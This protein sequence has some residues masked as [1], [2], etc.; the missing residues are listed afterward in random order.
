MKFEETVAGIGTLTDVRRIAGAH[1]VDHNQLSEAELRDAVVKVKPQYS[2]EETVRSAFDEALYGNPDKDCRV[3]SRLLLVD[4]LLEQYDFVLSEGE[5]EERLIA[6][7]QA[8]VDRSNEVDISDLACGKRNGSRYQDIELYAF[9]LETAWSH[10][11]SVSP[12]EA[13]LLRRLRER[14][15]INEW[16]HRT[17]EAKLS[18]YPKPGNELHTR[19]E[20]SKTRRYLQGLGLL[21]TVRD[22]NSTD[23][24]VIPQELAQLMREIVGKDMRTDCYRIMLGSKP[25]RSKNHLQ[26]ILTQ[27]CV[28]YSRYDNLDTLAE[29]VV[30]NVP[31]LQA[32]ACTSPRY[33]LSSDELAAWCRELDIS[34][35]GS[36]EERVHRVVAHFDALRPQVQAEADERAGWYDFYTELAWRD[37]ATLRAQHVIDKD[38]EIEAKFEGATRYL[39]SELLNHSPL[40]QSGS[41]HPDGLVSLGAR[42]LMWDNKSKETPVSL[43]DH[44][45]QFHDYIE[46]TDKHVPVF[47]VIG[48]DFTEDSEAEAIRYHAK[49]FERNILLIT[50]DE[51]KTLAEEW[52]SP[53]NRNREE[54]FPLGYLA[55]T[56]RF[57]RKSIGKL[58]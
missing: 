12:D 36:V 44:I 37:R 11:D 47:L 5:T 19:A 24:D 28:E 41:N 23:Y 20:T 16:D 14:L 48:P 42:Y 55:T 1:V 8:I 34:P 56:G 6:T 50:A 13:N 39:F 17:L 38:I 57:D 45:G 15:S 54:P 53:E 30:M 49:Y 46:R 26:E 33:G 35:Y 58:Y 9:V 21:F 29:R 10:Q 18:K 22:S 2:H 25:L 51:L 31:A 40:Q 27:S 4:V 43:K 7:E 52:A 32:I 3:L